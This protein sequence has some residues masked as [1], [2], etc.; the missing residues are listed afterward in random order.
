MFRGISHKL[1]NATTLALVLA[2]LMAPFANA[3]VWTDPTDYPPGSVVTIHGNNDADGVPGYWP[4]ATVNVAISGPYDPAV[5][6]ST[7][8]NVAVADDGTWTCTVT[9]WGNPA[10]A[11]GTYYYTAS[12]VDQ[13]GNSI[14]ET[15]WFT[16]DDFE[17]NSISPD[18]GP[19]TGGTLVTI[20]G[21]FPSGQEP[22]TVT[23]G[24]VA[25]T[26]VTRVD[27]N[28]LTAV[29]GAH[30]PGLVDVVVA[31]KLARAKTLADSYTY[32]L[33]DATCVVTGY[34][35][36]YDGNS[37]TAT[38]VCTGEN[39]VDLSYLLDL[40]GTVHTAVSVYYDTWY[41]AG[42]TY[43]KP[44]NG[45]VTDTISQAKVTATAGGGTGTYNG[46]V[47]T[48]SACVV[49]GAF[50]GDLTCANNPL[51]VGPDAGTYTTV[52]VV[53]GTGLTNFEITLV[54]GSYTISQ[55]EVTATAGSY[56]GTY[57][58]V[59]HSP[60]DCAVTG[61]YTSALT[62]TNNPASVGPDVGSGAV[63]PVVDY[64][65]VDP[66]N[67]VVISVN[68]SWEITPALVTA[69]AGSYSGAYN[70]VAHSPSACV[71][72]G[73][74]T[75]DL[76]CANNPAS[77][78][79]NVGSGA[80]AAVVSSPGGVPLTNFNI[81]YVAGSWSI[82]KALVTATAGSYSGTYDG[83]THSPTACAVTGAYTGALTC[84]NN[85]ASVGPNV[86]SGTVVPVVNYNGE[87]PSNFQ[88]TLTN[89]AWSITQQVAT[90]TYTSFGWYS[91]KSP[92]D[93]SFSV[94]LSATVSATSGDIRTATVTFKEGTTVLCTGPVGLV[95]PSDT[96]V[97]VVSCYWNGSLSSLSNAEEHD[98]TVVVGGNYTGTSDP[99]PITISP[100]SIAN[101]ITGGGY[102][103]LSNS[104]GTTPGALNSKLNFGFTVKY[105]KGGTNP[106]GKV[107]AIL[108]AA[109]GKKY[110]IKSTA[111]DSLSVNPVNLTNK[112]TGTGVFTAK[113]N[114]I[115]LSTGLTISGTYTMKL[116]VQDNG[117]PGGPKWNEDQL[118]LVIFN[119]AGGIWFTSK[120][121]GTQT[122]VQPITN[123]NLQVH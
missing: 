95:N 112:T 3:A 8:E 114:I 11:L 111:I 66:N 122:V 45:P 79:P 85:P 57:N 46:A 113:A 104:A 19:A 107:T 51:T 78:G 18:H 25:A 33:V 87:T 121:N 80:V 31:D 63:A 15:T 99:T 100:A 68:G 123:G 5:E 35:V 117:E 75:G 1:W 4:G 109:N 10:W 13:L 108:R 34:T 94:L 17:I 72:S 30:A 22:Y 81:T 58:G 47:H 77:V 39:N 6:S 21:K 29:T 50:T 64:H 26:S 102:L 67:F 54:N 41:F 12:S 89:G 105:N 69:T 42:D 96:K 119:S 93:K 118:Y 27:M 14:S 98:I 20:D 73:V 23:I 83:S 49:T 120:W 44:A 110:Q 65:G 52:P 16:D 60:S 32:D 106:Q 92:T 48:P 84:T 7:C 55:A 36:S 82:T 76:V 37:H 62:C 40:S 91:T 56:S 59:A 71:V 9:L 38:G 115:D 61:A 88:I 28:T 53:I 97:G 116:Y 86:G 101:F 43:Y 2:M 70:G 90:A 103:V 24:G 74:Y